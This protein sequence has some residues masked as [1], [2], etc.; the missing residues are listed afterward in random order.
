MIVAAIAVASQELRLETLLKQLW[1]P[2]APDA[3]RLTRRS[4]LLVYCR[5]A[6]IATAPKWLPG[7]L[8]R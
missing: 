4:P 6:G 7:A 2:S 1:R 5:I 3:E 8:S